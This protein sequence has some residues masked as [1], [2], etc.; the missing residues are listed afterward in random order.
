MEK[1]AH[2]HP[3]SQWLWREDTQGLLAVLNADAGVTRCVGGCVR[4]TLLGLADGDTEVDMA[5]TL[6]PDDVLAC[7]QAAKIRWLKTGFQYGTVTAMLPQGE[8]WRAYEITTLRQ[9]VAT[10]GRRA[11]I[12]Q[13]GDWAIDAARRDLTMNAL[14]ADADGTLHDPT[15]QG[16]ADLS[17]RRVQFIG[18]AAERIGEDYLR[19]LRYFR[20]HF[21]LTPSRPMD[22]DALAACAA[23]KHGVDEL[24]PERKRVEIMRILR[25]SHSATALAKLDAIGLLP[26]VLGV[27]AVNHVRLQKV[28][29]VS[30]EPM[31]RLTALLTG[32]DLSLVAKALRL[33]KKQTARIGAALATPKWH[34]ASDLPP[35]LY[36][37]GAEAVADQAVM[38]SGDGGD[39]G[40]CDLARTQAADYQR[41]HFPL[42][43]AMMQE[44]GLAA[45][46]DMGVMHKT[47]EDWWVAA[48]FPDTAAVEAE[49]KKR[50]K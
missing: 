26:A 42:T 32:D 20:F 7:L 47:L 5:T 4:D 17:A 21:A 31:L 45:G 29:R 43:G 18:D 23:A 19:V 1:L 9:D 30:A 6:S 27:A 8:G 16:L 22:A 39:L 46:P 10:D 15:G 33:S 38:Q 37:D 48:S 25:G 11:E 13:T 40:L 35:A 49:L 44:A 34:N 41:P 3:H 12:E 28:M 24:S 14:Y 50:L 2:A 36:Y